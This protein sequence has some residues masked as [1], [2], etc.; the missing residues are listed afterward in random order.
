[1]MQ[2]IYFV[3]LM[4]SIGYVFFLLSRFQKQISVYY[5]L[6]T[7]A[8]VIVN[9]GYLQ[10]A[11][12][13]TEEA[14]LLGNQ[15][16][17]LA[18]PFLLLF[19]IQ[20]IAD[21]CQTRIPAVVRVLCICICFIIFLGSSSAGRVDWYY[22]SVEMVIRDGYTFLKREY[23]PLHLLSP[24]YIVI[25]LGCGLIIVANALRKKKQVSY[26]VSMGSLCLLILCSAT[27]VGERIV[28]LKIELLPIAYTVCAGGIL[29][30]LNRVSTYDIKGI[31]RE[32]I[33]ESREYGFV[34][35]DAKFRLSGVDEQARHWFPELNK[36]KIDY[37][38]QDYSTDFLLQLKKW[39]LTE[40]SNDI[41]YFEREGRILE[42]SHSVPEMYRKKLHCIRIRD[43]TSQQ[44]YLR[45]VKQYNE[46]L[47]MQVKEKT[48]RLVEVQNDII[49]SMASIVENRDTNTGG[50]I[51]RTSEVLRVF[52]DHL[53]TTD[54]SS[55]LTR[56]IAERIVKA[57]PL[58]DFGK[59]AIPD[60]ILNKPGKF[61]S[62]EY[63]IMKLHAQKGSEIVARILQN[64]D[65]LSFKK[66]AVNIAHYHHEKWDGTGY[67]SGLLREEIPLEA[68]I[69]ALADVFD[70]LV[71]DRI[72]KGQFS[73]D[74]AFAIIEDSC[75]SHFDPVLCKAFLQCRSQIE[76]LYNN[77][78]D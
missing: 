14:V 58:H 75:G 34:I 42:V 22:R 73:F 59:I 69:M 28:G 6:M 25:T 29:L 8:V 50:H 33:E 49:V 52:V 31:S 5:I 46:E 37:R 12:A 47:G 70:A 68:R 78:F 41:V 7:V 65:D 60:S 26:F 17:C 71:S 56:E 53:L 76:T 24:I 43:D 1:M 3:M 44:Q 66:I 20:A 35:C 2:T 51:L 57:A 55:K 74:K 30:M 54:Y 10:I 18:Y 19:T 11:G 21:L 15:V 9:L 61:L 40:D 62:E 36:L 4:I 39:V 48:A 16:Y 67:P 72:Y 63:E 27:F 23:G 32:A 64:S 13:K 45:L 77:N 38:I